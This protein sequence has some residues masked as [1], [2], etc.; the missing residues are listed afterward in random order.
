MNRFN[1]SER[2]NLGES[3]HWPDSIWL[4][5]I[6]VAYISDGLLGLLLRVLALLHGVVHLPRHQGQIALQL[7]LLVNQPGVLVETRPTSGLNSTLSLLNS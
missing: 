5:F 2:F 1:I 4:W 6:G 7:L 3:C